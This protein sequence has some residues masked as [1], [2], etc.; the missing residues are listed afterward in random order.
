MRKVPILIICGLILGLAVVTGGCSRTA[1]SSIPAGSSPVN[2]AVTGSVLKLS[3][4]ALPAGWVGCPYEVRVGAD[5]GM[6]P[7]RFNLAGGA[8]PSGVRL[9]TGGILIGTPTARGNYSFTLQVKDARSTST[10]ADFVI[11]VN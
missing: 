9:S 4:V 3:S 8:L 2:A 5:G 1:S 6:L 11:H 7:C 10:T